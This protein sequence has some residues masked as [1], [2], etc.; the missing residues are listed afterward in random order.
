MSHCIITLDLVSSLSPDD[1]FHQSGDQD[2]NDVIGLDLDYR[3]Q[4][5]V[6]NEAPPTLNIKDRRGP[7]YQKAQSVPGGRSHRCLY[8]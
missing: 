2:C 6:Q 7:K 3:L 1:S 8:C 4:L 5:S